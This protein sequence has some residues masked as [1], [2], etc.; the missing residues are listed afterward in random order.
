MTF[1]NDKTEETLRVPP[2]NELGES[3]VELNGETV[4]L[5][6]YSDSGDG[7]VTLGDGTQF[8]SGREFAS[9]IVEKYLKK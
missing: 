2:P 3:V 7:S 8:K 4:E 6:L 5:V 1:R 9:Y